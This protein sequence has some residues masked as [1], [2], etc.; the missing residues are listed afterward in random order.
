MIIKKININK[1][2][3]NI[4]KIAKILNEDYNIAKGV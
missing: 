2:N 3:K 4:Q 1:K